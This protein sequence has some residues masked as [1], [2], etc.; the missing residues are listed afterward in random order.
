M[1]GGVTMNFRWVGRGRDGS[2][3]SGELDAPSKEQVLLRLRQQHIAVTKIEAG[4][5]DAEPPDPDSVRHHAPLEPQPASREPRRL[6]GLFVSASLLGAGTLAGWLGAPLAL[7][8]VPMVIGALMLALTILSLFEGPTA[9][10]YAWT[11]RKAKELN[12]RKRR[13]ADRINRQGTPS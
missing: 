6:A 8:A 13:R 11:D 3:I 7:V 9:A 2:Q 12:A 4:G 1:S 10:I 5:G